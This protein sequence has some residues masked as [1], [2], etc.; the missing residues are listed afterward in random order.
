MEMTLEELIA[1]LQSLLQRRRHRSY[2]QSRP[3]SDPSRGQGRLLAMLKLQ[4]GIATKDLAYMLGIRPASLNELVAKLEKSGHVTRQQSDTD[5]RVWLVKLT[6]QGRAE[7]TTV[8]TEEAFASLSQ[9]DQS[10]LRS[11]LVTVIANLEEELGAGPD[12]HDEWIADLRDHMGQ[13]HFDKWVKHVEERFGPH[14][15]ER[16]RPGFGGPKG[17]RGR[18]PGPDN[19][20]AHGDDRRDWHEG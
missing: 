4:D 2:R 15:A 7:P 18:G 20:R 5:G 14:W 8:G 17:R 3:W 19:R 9:E 6:D 13:E 16:I 12:D 10:K 11:Y 1:R